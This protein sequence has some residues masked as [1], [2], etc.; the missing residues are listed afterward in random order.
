MHSVSQYGCPGRVMHVLK[1]YCETVKSLQ[2]MHTWNTINTVHTNKLDQA[3]AVLETLEAPAN[4]P[5]LEYLREHGK[6]NLLDLALRLQTSAEQLEQQLEQLC[7]CK[8]VVRQEDVIGCHYAL[9]FPQLAKTRRIA[10]ALAAF[11]RE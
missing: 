6:T 3:I 1:P 2:P 9:N 7:Q 11:Y 10:K 8:M 4:V 5:I